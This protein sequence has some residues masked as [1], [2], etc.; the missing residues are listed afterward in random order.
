MQRSFGHKAYSVGAAIGR[1]PVTV[2]TKHGW[3][4]KSVPLSHNARPYRIGVSQRCR[5]EAKANR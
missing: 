3:D 5:E 4:N 2:S 1:P